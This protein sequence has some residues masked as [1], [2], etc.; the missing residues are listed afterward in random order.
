[1]PLEIEIKF[2]TPDAAAMRAKCIAVGARPARK[3]VLEHNIRFEDDQHRLIQNKALLR[4]RKDTQNTLT[5]K[6]SPESPN[7]Q[8]KIFKELEVVVNDF[9]GMHQ[10]LGALGYHQVQV[11]EKYR[12]ILIL[13]AAQ[14]CLDAM[15]FGNFLEIEGSQSE[16]REI[17]NRLGFQWSNRI[18][19]NYLELFEIIRQKKNL[20]FH[21]VTFANFKN[22]RV[23]TSDFLPL[24]CAS[25]TA[26]QK[27]S[28]DAIT[29]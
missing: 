14:L 24:F 28:P 9:N 23:K 18:L 12:E 3:R 8:F 26:N 2:L 6:S 16:I 17:A 25:T 29:E 21:D 15:P 22:I 7:D 27:S 20:T 10:I 4:L 13:G 11:Y 19:K 5:F 1:M